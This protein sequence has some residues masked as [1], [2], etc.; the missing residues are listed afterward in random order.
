MALKFF[1]IKLIFNFYEYFIIMLSYL[2]LFIFHILIGC[3]KF[4]TLYKL[5]NRF[6]FLNYFKPIKKSAIIKLT[7]CILNFIYSTLELIL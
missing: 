7:K 5:V 4:K 3:A 6:K 1:C 2:F